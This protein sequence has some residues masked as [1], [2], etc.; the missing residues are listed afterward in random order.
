MSGTG[1]GD[2]GKKSGGRTRARRRVAPSTIERA[3]EA[4]GERVDQPA[5]EPRDGQLGI[6]ERARGAMLG[7]AVGDALGAT[8]EF[9][10]RIASVK[11]YH[12]EM[13]GGGP[14]GLQPGQWTDDTAMAL[15]L[16]KSLLTCQSFDPN[17]VMDRFVAW[18]RRGEYSC[19]GD[20]FDIGN[21]TRQ[22]LER[23]E[24]TG[25]PFAGSMHE[26]TAGNG[27]LMRLAP[28]ALFGLDDEAEAVRVAREQSRLTHAAPVCMDACD[29]F[30]R[31]L[32]LTILGEEDP[33]KLALVKWSG[34]PEVQRAK[35][36]YWNGLRRKDIR[37]TGY[38]V[39]TLEAALWAVAGSGSFEQ[40]VVLACNLGGDSDTIGAVA[41][42]LAGAKW[43]ERAI[44]KRWLE[45]LAR[46]HEIGA[47]ALSLVRTSS[48]VHLDRS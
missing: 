14:H 26:D 38:V 34:H 46:R 37:S 42:A 7:L 5:P 19:T 35:A 16:S 39:D 22:A 32:R 23:F 36:A 2:G 21:T 31:L 44:P 33:I 4:G 10:P 9:G 3:L 43:G 13:T 11:D 40:A 12:R 27:S 24:R 28:V 17:D 18:Y 15:A 29:Y 30:V 48:E 20:C 1:S 25:E 45:P 6:I 47:V 41:G 8:L